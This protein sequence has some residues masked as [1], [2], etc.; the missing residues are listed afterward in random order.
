MTTVIALATLLP[1]RASTSDIDSVYEWLDNDAGL[2]YGHF[3]PR[4]NI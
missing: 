3:G 4:C 1:D 2:P